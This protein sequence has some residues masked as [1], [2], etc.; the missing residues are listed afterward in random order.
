MPFREVSSTIRRQ[1]NNTSRTFRKAERFLNLLSFEEFLSLLHN[2]SSDSSHS[3]YLL[4]FL[5]PSQ[6]WRKNFKANYSNILVNLLPRFANVEGP[7][8]LR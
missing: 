1:L 2:S 6:S 3:F 4:S 8:D 5:D 7:R